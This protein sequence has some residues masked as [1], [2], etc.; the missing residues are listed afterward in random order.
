M[1]TTA[2]MFSDL[3][4]SD[5]DELMK[6][7]NTGKVD[8]KWFGVRREYIMSPNKATPVPFHVCVRYLGD[9]RSQLRKSESFR[10]PDGSMGVIPE[11]RGELVRLSVMYGLYHDKIKTLPKVAPKVHVT[12]F[13][14]VALEWP[15]FNPESVSYLYNT[16]ETTNIDIRTELDRTRSQ[17]AQMEQR[18]AALT[19]NMIADD[20]D[21]GEAPDDSLGL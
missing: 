15:I 16:T 18:I 7:T 20:E 21:G 12:T 9:P 10:T 3:N 13:N 4:L 2:P 17:M 6:V 19:N 5:P 1:V 8:I 11:R 14:D